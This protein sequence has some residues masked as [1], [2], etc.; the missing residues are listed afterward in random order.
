MKTTP[1]ACALALLGLTATHDARATISMTDGL[2]TWQGSGHARNVQGT[3]LG[4][5]DVVM[6]RK[7]LGPGKIRAD[8]K[9]TLRD[10]QIIVF[11]HEYE[12]L[13]SGG[14]RLTSTNGSGAG[15][16]FSNGMCQSYEQRSD[17]H[18]FATTIVEDG[19]DKIRVLVTE[20][21]KGQAVR[22]IEQTLTKK[23]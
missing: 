9:V 18:A 21:D 5:F 20:L 8:G 16:C 2:G 10:G 13:Q 7:P 15:R 12:D 14:Y 23:P 4:R 11:W 19:P 17:G 6:V 3:D 1:I 22:F